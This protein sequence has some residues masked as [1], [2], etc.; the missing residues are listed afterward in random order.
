LEDYRPFFDPPWAEKIAQLANGTRLSDPIFILTTNWRAAANTCSM[1][2][3]L[4]HSLKSE[5]SGFLQSQQPFSQR[6]AEALAERLT[7]EMTESL[8]HG[9]RRKLAEAVKRIGHDVHQQ[10]GQ[11][12]EAK[13]DMETFWNALLKGEEFQ[14]ALWGSQRIGYGS[15]Y[16]AYENFV[17]QCIS[18]GLGKPHYRGQ[19]IRG[20][21]RD[22]TQLFDMRIADYCLASRQVRVARL[23]RNALAHGGGQETEP[24]RAF[25][26]GLVIEN[27]IIQILASDTRGLFEMLK[28]RVYRLAEKAVELPGIG[29]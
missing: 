16:H 15:I 12:P 6:I 11:P 22:A 4:V 14:L 21:I 8:S 20:L 9:K 18:I 25:R 5:W 27:G 28:R 26:H 23:V 2:W 7:S 24:L 29:E 19:R 13:Y 1:P 10:V 3:L 17:R